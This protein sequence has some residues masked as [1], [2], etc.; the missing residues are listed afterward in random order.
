MSHQGQ[1]M[2]PNGCNGG[3][4]AAPTSLRVT[5]EA[6]RLAPNVDGR[7]WQHDFQETGIV[8]GQKRTRFADIIEREGELFRL[9]AA[10]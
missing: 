4:R 5:V 10:E 7:H 2:S 3:L 8:G 9:L 6:A 1:P